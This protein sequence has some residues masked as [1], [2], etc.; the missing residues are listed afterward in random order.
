MIDILFLGVDH[1]HPADFAYG[2]SEHPWWLLVFVKSKTIFHTAVG[3]MYANPG[4]VAVFPPN[5][6]I[7]YEAWGEAFVNTYIR[8]NTDEEFITNGSYPV[9]VPIELNVPESIDYLTNTVCSQYYRGGVNAHRT[10][11]HAMKGIFYVI[12]ESAQA[13]VVSQQN[14]LLTELRY[15]I[16]VAPYKQWTLKGMADRLHVST[17]YLSAIY[18]RQFGVSCLDDVVNHR[19]ELA[20]DLMFNTNDK[21][22]A[23]AASC[24][25]Q[26]MEHFSRQFKKKTGMS[27]SAY[28]RMSRI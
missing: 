23:I 6:N 14:K 25:Y 10:I 22:E 24:G 16:S 1:T 5:L 15:D 2:I 21:L 3:D 26:S 13:K 17:G 19:I 27:P 8:F 18:K 12:T 28:R 11:F 4:T 20:K 7:Y 9:G